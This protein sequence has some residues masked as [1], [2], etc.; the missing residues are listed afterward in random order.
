MVLFSSRLPQG[1]DMRRY[2]DDDVSARLARIEGRG[3]ARRPKPNVAELTSRMGSGDIPIGLQYRAV[4]RRPS[5]RFTS[6]S[7]GS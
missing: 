3:L 5:C 7:G 4:R 6:A 1:A 2:V